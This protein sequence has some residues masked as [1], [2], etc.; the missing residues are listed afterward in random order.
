MEPALSFT[1]S[2]ERL[3]SNIETTELQMIFEENDQG[4]KYVDSYHGRRMAE[5]YLKSHG[6]VLDYSS[7]GKEVIFII[8]FLFLNFL[9]KQFFFLEK[10][11]IFL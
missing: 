10:K 4:I 2:T 9:K 11:Y 7:L 1:T 5:I 3:R 6:L 8:K